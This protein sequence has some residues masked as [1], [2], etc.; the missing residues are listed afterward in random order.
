M[1]PAGIEGLVLAPAVIEV[2]G[3]VAGVAVADD[4][5]FDAFGL[6]LL[7]LVNS[8]QLRDQLCDEDLKAER[9][10]RDSLIHRFTDLQIH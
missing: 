10:L 2:V 8:H 9:Y 3:F 7:L 1:A 5:M 4:G 6:Q